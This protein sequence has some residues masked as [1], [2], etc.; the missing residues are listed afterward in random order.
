M[1]EANTSLRRLLWIAFVLLPVPACV[2]A[3]APATK[4][5]NLAPSSVM[6]A[7]S[8]PALGTWRLNVAKSRFEF[9]LPKT[10]VRTYVSR[11]ANGVEATFSRTDAAGK[12]YEVTYSANYDERDY[13]Y[14]GAP[15]GDTI[16][17]K[18][19]DAFTVDAVIKKAG[20][21]VQRSRTVTSQDRS[22]RT[23]TV[24]AQT[25]AGLR[26]EVAVFDKLSDLAVFLPGPGTVSPVPT[27]IPKPSYTPEAMGQ[28]ISG[29]A[30]VECI[31]LPGGSCTNAHLVRSLDPRFGLDDQALRNVTEWKFTPGSRQGQPVPVLVTID[32]SFS[33]T[34]APAK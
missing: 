31:V 14:V 9:G 33:T 25:A 32:V 8:D 34:P 30:R 26:T 6:A 28:H 29:V 24:R 19:V 12:P 22:T 11:E 13:P 7:P 10:E 5:A 3:C 4:P 15:E 20:V 17:L 21:V 18:I 27:F 1:R 16:A 23:A 2:I